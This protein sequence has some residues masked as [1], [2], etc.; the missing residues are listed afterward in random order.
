ME[1]ID[2]R[3]NKEK[4]EEF[5]WNVSNK[6]RYTCDNIKRNAVK[7]G[8]WCVEH[9]TE[10]VAFIGAGVAVAKTVSGIGTKV[11]H[12]IN[13]HNSKLSVYC[14][15][16]QGNVRIKHVLNYDEARELRD[17]MN[18]GYTKFEALDMMGLLKK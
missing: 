16:I 2:M 18:G 9:P 11:G 7:A 1:V 6:A 17:L 5:R 14:N 4:W 8:T 15:D 12:A 10:A 13:D 3:S